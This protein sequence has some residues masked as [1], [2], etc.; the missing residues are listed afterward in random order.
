MIW[1]H[2]ELSG[3]EPIA[4]PPR[5]DDD[6]AVAGQSNAP[7]PPLIGASARKVAPGTGRLRVSPD[8]PRAPARRRSGLGDHATSR[9]FGIPRRVAGPFSAK[10]WSTS[11]A[12]EDVRRPLPGNS[13]LGLPNSVPSAGFLQG[14]HRYLQLNPELIMRAFRGY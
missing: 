2:G 13:R 10:M 4:L 3:W 11:D 6:N 7:A 1:V 14:G 8:L 12:D 5:S 9:Y